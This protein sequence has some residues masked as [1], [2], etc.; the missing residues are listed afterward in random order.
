M[1]TAEKLAIAVAERL[2]ELGVTPEALVSSARTM[3]QAVVSMSARQKGAMER[4]IR[5]TEMVRPAIERRLPNLDYGTVRAIER[6]IG[7][8]EFTLF[9]LSAD[10]RGLP[11]FGEEYI[12]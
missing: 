3:S 12:P 6:A 11:E 9:A 8:S 10:G 2:Q 7:F 5:D 4:D 1:I